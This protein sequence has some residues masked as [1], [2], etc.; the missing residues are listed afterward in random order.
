[1]RNFL[2]VMMI[3]L[4]IFTF[5]CSSD[6]K[7]EDV[8]AKKVEPPP[9]PIVTQAE[10]KAK[11]TELADGLD[12]RYDDMKEKYYYRCNADMDVRPRIWLIPY[13]TVDKN[14]NVFL[15]QDIVYLGK[16]PLHFQTLYVKTKKGVES[17]AYKDVIR[18]YGGEE[19]MG[20]MTYDVYRKLKEGVADR[21]I[22]IRLEGRTFGD[23]ELTAQEIA[24]FAKVFAVYEYFCNVKIEQ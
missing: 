10:A 16:E 4:L 24:D 1:M 17:F 5:G 13:V 18:S 2:F 7:K 9:I 23:R 15:G 6:I 11:L 20:E 8:D 12:Y 22:K 21:Y 19:Y 3:I 14:Y